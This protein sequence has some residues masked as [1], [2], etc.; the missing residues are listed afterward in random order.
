[1]AECLGMRLVQDLH[2][3][4]VQFTNGECLCKQ[5]F[6]FRRR[7][8]EKVQKLVD[9]A[10]GNGIACAQGQRV[11]GVGCNSLETVKNEFLKIR[12]FLTF[13]EEPNR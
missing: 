4:I 1:M 8:C 12:D 6:G 2:H 11:G 7:L 13:S 3:S 5:L 9:L 10:I